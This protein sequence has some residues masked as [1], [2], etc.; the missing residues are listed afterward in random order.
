MRLATFRTQYK[1]SN[2]VKM[3]I[4]PGQHLIIANT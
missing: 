3:A 4:V 1:E 2:C